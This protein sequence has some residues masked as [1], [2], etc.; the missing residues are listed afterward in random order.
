M[1]LKKRFIIFFGIGG[2]LLLLLST[3][4]IFNRME[5]AMK[6]QLEQQF[7]A[8]IKKRFLDFKNTLIDK[9]KKFE[10]IS[11][12]PMFKSMRFHELTLNKAALK[13]D[14]RQLELYLYEQIRNQPELIQIRY[15]NGK[16]L[17]VFR[18]E[19]SGISQNLSDMSQNKLIESKLDLK[20][21]KV[22]VT[23][24]V[25]KNN[26]TI[27]VWW[28]PV[29]LSSEINYGVLGVGVDYQ[30]LLNLVE[31]LKITKNEVICLRNGENKVLLNNGKAC[32]INNTDYWS[33]TEDLSTTGLNWKITLSTKK[34]SLLSNVEKI[35]IIVFFII[36]PLIA[37]FSFAMVVLFSNNI[38]RTIKQLVDAAKLMGKDEKF[39]PIAINS[40]NELGVLAKEMNR[41]A[42]M[43][44]DHRRELKEKKRD[45][46]AI[47]DHSPTAI[48]V[49]NTKGCFTFINL[50]FEKFL[51][52]SAAD[53][54]GKTTHDI[55]PEEV[56]AK[57]E[58]NDR[59]IIQ[60]CKAIE[61]VDKHQHKGKLHTYI[62]I[63]FP[64]LNDAG[65]IYAVCGISTDITERKIM[66]DALRRSQKM[67]AMGQLTGGIAHDFNNQL[68]IIV[69][70]LDFLKEDSN[71]N[72]ETRRWIAT[73]T[74]AT[75]RCMD[76]TR[77]LL[78]F[79]RTQSDEK[80]V[81]DFNASLTELKTMYA[82]S[83]TPA[84]KIQYYLSEDL[85]L[86]EINQGEFQDATLNLVL[87]ARDAMPDGGTILIETT[88]KYLDED[89]VELNPGSQTGDYV[90]IMLSDTGT[91][92]D[93][94]TQEKIFEPFYTTKPKGKGTGL[95]MSMVYGFVKR[96]GGFI[97]IYSELNVGTSIHLYLPRASVSK[98]DT[99]SKIIKD[100]NIPTGNESILIV[101]DES[102]LLQLADKYLTDLG[103]KTYL[104]KNPKQALEIF[105]KHSDIAMLFSDV[106]MPGGV[107]GYELAEL[108]TRK[109]PQLKVLLS[110][111]FTSKTI[112]H[113]GQARFN[114]ELLKKPY[115]KTD[116]G[117]RIRLV[118]DKI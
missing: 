23:Q 92:M 66:E 85:W 105:A 21:G 8:D 1:S 71:Q 99:L 101:D 94:A 78:S 58:K 5:A 34:S 26:K 100:A 12:L 40:N 22:D 10:D 104:A 76:L 42:F 117:H 16:G 14:I 102:D 79:S 118:L 24:G 33:V 39:T 38:S 56:A 17:E 110:S 107:N 7:R 84:I 53:I 28:L 113:N 93:E 109:N 60:N 106:V 4:L 75:L 35:K 89:Y 73:S 70:Y 69:G 96:F 54:L 88:N 62:S 80:T 63:M 31:Q 50:Q 29:Y 49:K 48:Y 95:G 9:E 103:Y 18:I 15:V 82:R 86:T 52:L 83:V 51:G 64:L 72:Q 46:Q 68:G 77:Q 27:F 74:K 37:F 11:K 90:E 97:K 6:S 114:Q 30:Y 36:F 81:V 20:L 98:T 13:N 32:E 111:G 47:M 45:L 67:D 2:M 25:D 115:R 55:F 44:E 57:M 112:A 59:K 3:Y 108:I 43:I 41:S 19:K 91:G 116:L 65:E 61:S 87:N